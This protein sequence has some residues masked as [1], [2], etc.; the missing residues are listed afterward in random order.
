MCGDDVNIVV[1]SSRHFI[2]MSSTRWF[3][4]I[5]LGMQKCINLF[6]TQCFAGF[7][8]GNDTHIVVLSSR[9]SISYVITLTETKDIP[10]NSYIDKTLKKAW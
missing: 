5:H 4:Q 7:I 8:C 6:E 3:C 10:I 9:C 1:F 2:S